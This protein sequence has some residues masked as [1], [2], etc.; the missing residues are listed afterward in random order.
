MSKRTTLVI[1][2]AVA[3]DA[4][5]TSR[6]SSRPVD[7]ARRAGELH[8]L[9]RLA[10]RAQAT[11]SAITGCRL[12]YIAVRVGPRTRTPRYQNRYASTSASSPL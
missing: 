9:R 11:S 6:V 12:E 3:V 1:R 2:T 7:D 5:L 4:G 8:H 10:Q